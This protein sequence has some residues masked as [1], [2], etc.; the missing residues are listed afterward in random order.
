LVPAWSRL[1]ASGQ[2]VLVI[3]REAAIVFVVASARGFRSFP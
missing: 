3:Q 1:A 2:V